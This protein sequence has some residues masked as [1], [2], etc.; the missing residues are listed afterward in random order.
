M[1]MRIGDMWQVL[2]AKSDVQFE[3]LRQRPAVIP[4]ERPCVGSEQNGRPTLS[5]T[6]GR[7][8]SQEGICQG[9]SCVTYRTYLARRSIAIEAIT[10]LSVNKGILKL[11]IQP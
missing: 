1:V 3:P 11:V 4:I 6:V 10:T 7:S 9:V 2:P 8:K 5:L